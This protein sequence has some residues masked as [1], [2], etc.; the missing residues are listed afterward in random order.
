MQEAYLE[1]MYRRGRVLAAYLYLPREAGA[2][3]TRTTQAEPGMIIDYD[4]HGQP[5]G[6]EITAPAQVVLPQRERDSLIASDRR[7]E[8]VTRC[9]SELVGA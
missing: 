1:A 3:S 4:R 7:R 6:I 2:K 9:R 5:I 8:G